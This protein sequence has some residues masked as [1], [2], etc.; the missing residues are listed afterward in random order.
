MER[1]L[2]CP[3]D[4]SLLAVHFEF[5][6]ENA[7]ITDCMSVFYYPLVYMT[8]RRMQ[9]SSLLAETRSK[10]AR[11][12]SQR[13]A[14]KADFETLARLWL[15]TPRLDATF[16]LFSLCALAEQFLTNG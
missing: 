10:S 9:I 15:D 1:F 3:S 7:V 14:V 5:E 4:V 2:R 8:P 16:D 11:T 13:C 6:L 12:A